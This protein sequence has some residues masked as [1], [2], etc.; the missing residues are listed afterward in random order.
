MLSSEQQEL[1]N[2][3]NYGVKPKQI[4]LELTLQVYGCEMTEDLVVRLQRLLERLEA[5]DQTDPLE[6]PFKFKITTL[7]F[8]KHVLKCPATW[9]F[10]WVLQACLSFA[11]WMSTTM[12]FTKCH[13]L[14]V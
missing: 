2:R 5:T 9:T 10:L 3:V 12:A 8:G 7:W 13:G 11:R 4:V 14:I 6:F 1:L